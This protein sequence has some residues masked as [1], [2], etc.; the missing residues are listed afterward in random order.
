M[1][2]NTYISRISKTSP[3]K[4]A[5]IETL[6]SRVPALKT[7]DIDITP[8][9]DPNGFI[10]V[11]F[12]AYGPQKHQMWPIGVEGKPFAGRDDTVLWLI[13]SSFAQAYVQATGRKGTDKQVEKLVAEWG[14][15]EPPYVNTAATLE[16]QAV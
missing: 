10:L 12:G 15:A 13:A 6:L 9:P 11:S 14:F 8:E 3:R 16:P 5:A 1:D 2:I 7:L 4:A